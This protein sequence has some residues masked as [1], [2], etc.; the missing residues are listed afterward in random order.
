MSQKSE[1]QVVLPSDAADASSRLVL[2]LSD[3]I[4]TEVRQLSAIQVA[5]E[6]FDRVEIGRVVATSLD[7]QPGALRGWNEC[8]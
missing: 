6:S 8:V 7:D 3:G 1:R 4:D 5:P 2:G